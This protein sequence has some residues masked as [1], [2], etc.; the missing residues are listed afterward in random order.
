MKDLG[1]AHFVLG[2][3][4]ERNRQARTLSISQQQYIK[5]VVERFD[6][7]QCD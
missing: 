3:Q 5:K 4:I 1:E 6:M 2:I 7:S